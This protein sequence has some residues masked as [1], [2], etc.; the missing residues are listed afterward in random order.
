MAAPTSF[1]PSENGHACIIVIDCEFADELIGQFLGMS[2][3]PNT[4]CHQVQGFRQ[5]VGPEDQD[6]P[7]LEHMVLGRQDIRALADDA[8]GAT[9]VQDMMADQRAA[10]VADA[11]VFQR[12]TRP[13][14]APQSHRR[15]SAAAERMVAFVHQGIEVEVPVVPDALHGA[16]G[17]FLRRFPVPQAVDHADQHGVRIAPHPCLVTAEAALPEGPDRDPHAGGVV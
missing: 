15:T 17:G 2:R 8:I 6:V 12:A 4:V 7:V 14:D 1:I 9:K 5:T 11:Q 13:V 3:I 16:A 10:G